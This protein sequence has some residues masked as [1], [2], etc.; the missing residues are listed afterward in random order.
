MYSSFKA[1]SGTFSEELI[2][3]TKLGK[4]AEIGGFLEKLTFFLRF[5]KKKFANIKNILTFVSG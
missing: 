3:Y 5:F 1:I 2:N 4:G